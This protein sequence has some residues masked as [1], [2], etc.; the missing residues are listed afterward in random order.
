MALIIFVII[1]T[2]VFAVITFQVKRNSSGRTWTPDK[3]FDD[4]RTGI[5]RSQKRDYGSQR[6]A[7]ESERKERNALRTAAKSVWRE[8]FSRC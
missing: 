5:T 2:G 7:L 1:T 6:E 3:P 4:E 8:N